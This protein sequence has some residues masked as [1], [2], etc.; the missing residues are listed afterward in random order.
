MENRMMNIA[1]TMAAWLGLLTLMSASLVQARIEAEV[2]SQFL[3]SGEQAIL[4]YVITDEINPQANLNMPTIEDL[5]VRQI[6]YGAEPRRGFGRRMEYVYRYAVSSYKPGKYEIPS[7]ELDTGGTILETPAIKIRVFAET[8]L[9]WS[10][11]DTG[12]IT[13]SYAAAFRT[14]D[15]TPYLKE[16]IPTEL[17]VYI[18]NDQRVEDWG[19]P[20]FKR[21]GVAAWRFEPR[22]KI[23]RAIL[24]GRNYFAVSYPS[25]LSPTRAG[26]VGIGP[27]SLRL[28]TVQTSLRDFGSA[29]YAP[30]NLSIPKLTLNAK[31]LPEGAPEGF[32]DAVG[33]FTLDV[34]TSESE[35]REGDPVSVTIVVSG[36]GN[37]DTLD[38]P[39]PMDPEGWK[40]YPP[41]QTQLG[42]RRK[43][44]GATSFTQF[45][46]PQI[47][48]SQI[49]PFQLVFFDPEAEQYET[50]ISRPIP[51]SI[52][53]STNAGMGVAS[54]PMALPMPVEEM[55]DILGIVEAGHTRLLPPMEKFTSYGWQWIPAGIAL[56]LIIRIVQLRLA[57]KMHRDPEK[58]ELRKEFNKLRQSPSGAKEFYRAV[59]HF[60]ERWLGDSND[61]F[62]KDMLTKRDDLCFRSDADANKVNRSDRQRIL[63]KLKDLALPLVVF[64][65]MMIASGQ[66]RAD[67]P[68]VDMPKDAESSA[69][70]AY[71]EGRYD[72]AAALWLKSEPYEDLSADTLYNIGNAAYRLGSPG[73]AA[74][75]WRRAL[76]R[77]S[78]HAE[79]R[80][81]L[82]FFERKFGSITIQREDYQYT[83]AKLELGTW[84]NMIWAGCWMIGIGVLIFP[85]TKFGSRLRIVAI[86]SLVTAPLL[87]ITGLAAWY[88]YPDDAHFANYEDQAVITVDMAVLRTD[89]ARN[90]PRVIDAPAG[91]LCEVLTRTGDWVYVAFTNNSRGWVKSSELQPL[92][93]D[94]TPK[95]PRP[96]T[97]KDEE[98]KSA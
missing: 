22:P 12:G 93:P 80:Q 33:N 47:P 31:P 82:R 97:I 14:T 94:E 2:S 49:P 44:S 26:E 24:R 84:K 90:A 95:P 56:L 92:I 59:G 29:F 68:D 19:I 8:D 37:L 25:T 96:A 66:L 61:D 76:T 9:H 15:D 7:I 57:P 53:P 86:A 88:Y 36:Q 78:D 30:A 11:V 50:R 71:E 13:M 23:G 21:D 52:L 85:A 64:A 83:L 67:M 77:D 39:Q 60:I 98:A 20:E 10:T 74:L 63:R 45:L 4:E 3:V 81:N 1:R 55:T 89:A 18:P 16:V 69:E 5:S 70:A 32:S 40:V 34:R 46:R 58:V 41:S 73:E 51:L 35:V 79:A 65:A 62:T 48:Q 54:V 43:I 87:A 42:E 72:D 75:Y 38:C 91:S 17:K 28:I 6:G 27:A